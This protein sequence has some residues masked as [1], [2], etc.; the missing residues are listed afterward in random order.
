MNL[1]IWCLEGYRDPLWECYFTHCCNRF[2]HW[3]C[4]VNNT[5]PLHPIQIF[6]PHCRQTNFGQPYQLPLDYDV[7]Y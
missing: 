4:R 2:Y 6:C 7:R 3:A 1:C 5:F